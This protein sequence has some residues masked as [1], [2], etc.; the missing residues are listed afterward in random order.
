M[1]S[2]K[3]RKPG[4]TNVLTQESSSSS[5]F[6]QAPIPQLPTLSGFRW[7]TEVTISTS[8]EPKVMRPGVLAEF[9]LSDG[10]KQKLF[11][12]LR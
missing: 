9:T 11:L 5:N 2:I 10:R 3:K 1:T 7:R 8:N 4:N 6:V 12:D